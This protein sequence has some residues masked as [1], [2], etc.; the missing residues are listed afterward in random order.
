[1]SQDIYSSDLLCSPVPSKMLV[2]H[3]TSSDLD[4]G[5]PSRIGARC[6]RPKAAAKDALV[7]S[8]LC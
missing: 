1:M 3:W 2:G 8:C 4:G 7:G 6:T 5:V